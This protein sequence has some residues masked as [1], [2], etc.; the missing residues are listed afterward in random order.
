MNSVLDLSERLSVLPILHGSGDFALQVRRHLVNWSPDCVALP[1]P[2]SFAE[3]VEQGV[4]RLPQISVAIQREISIEGAYNYVPIDPC[5]GVI[6]AVRTAMDLGTHRAYVDLEVGSYE[7]NELVL[8]DPY[9]LKEVSLERFVAAMV[10]ALTAPNDGDQRL[11]RIRRM[12]YELHLLE[13]EHDRIVLVCS[14]ADWPWIRQAYSDR[15]RYTK[16]ERSITLPVCRPLAA[17]CLY[18]AL[19]ELPHVT[20]QYEHRRA[21][22]LADETLSIDGIKALLIDARDRWMADSEWGADQWM[23]PQ[24]MGLLLKYVRNLTL[25]ESRLTPDL[26]NLALAAK[27]VGG[28]DF[29]LVLLEAACEYPLQSLGGES[30]A[31]AMGVG[32]VVDEEGQPIPAK[33][34]L[35]GVARV[36]RRLPLKPNPP[37]P[38]KQQWSQQWDPYGQCSYPPEDGR[39]ERFQQHVREQARIL[40]G[41]DLAKVEKFQSSLKD[42]LDLRETLRNWHT[43]DV[44]V[45]EL[46][47]TRGQVEVVVF[48]FDVPANPSRYTWQST[49]YAEHG[50]ESTLSF[51]ATPFLENMVGPGIGQALYGGCSFIFPPRAIPNIWTDD[52]LHFTQTLEERLLGGALLHS[53]ERR[54]VLVAPTLPSARWRRMARK[55]GRQIVYIPLGRFSSAMVDRL[56]RFHVL[57]NKGVRSYAARYVRSF[58]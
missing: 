12:A 35:Q 39:I 49:W 8:P 33:N 44:Y 52:R 17:D 29:A 38:K 48:L 56:R 50:E 16:H 41:D 54:V 31:L 57:N 1:L 19:G 18:F 3:P 26:Y 32:Q 55:L 4:N 14:V 58:R 45:R 46:P 15:A 40:L 25:M 51:F 28:D 53:Q 9:A 43:G 11:A 22:M 30:D 6:S 47:A 42:G 21:E 37:A 20:H 36:W 7:E 34:R 13:L 23:G 5:Q 24:Q 27:Q 10:P 2:P